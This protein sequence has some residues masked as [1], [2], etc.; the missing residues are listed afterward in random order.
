MPTRRRAAPGPFVRSNIITNKEECKRVSGFCLWLNFH[1]LT[2]TMDDDSWCGDRQSLGDSWC[3]DIWVILGVATDSSLVW[4]HSFGGI[5][6][7]G[8]IFFLWAP[9]FLLFSPGIGHPHCFLQ[10]STLLS[11]GIYISPGNCT[12]LFYFSASSF[13]HD[14]LWQH[15][16]SPVLFCLHLFFPFQ[17][18]FTAT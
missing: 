6:W 11:P 17:V 13:F 12:T 9:T 16:S 1:Y 15:E 5:S 18:F 10:A 4:C 8:D 14:S 3:G 2:F 7:Y